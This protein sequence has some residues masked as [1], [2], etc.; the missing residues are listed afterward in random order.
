MNKETIEEV[1]E[2]SIKIRT[3]TDKEKIIRFFDI[4]QHISSSLTYDYDYDEFL[5]KIEF[6]LEC[7]GYSME[8]TDV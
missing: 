5:G 4:R 6:E 7:L 2:F 3:N 8:I 1:L